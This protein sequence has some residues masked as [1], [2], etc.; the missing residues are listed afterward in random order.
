MEI[1]L[2]SRTAATMPHPHEQKLHDVV[3]SLMFSS[4]NFCVAALTVDR[5]RRSPIASPAPPLTVSRN[6][7]RRLIDVAP[8]VFGPR[9]ACSSAS[10]PALGLVLGSMIRA[11]FPGDEGIVRAIALRRDPNE[12]PVLIHKP[13]ILVA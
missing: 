10:I 6:Q 7:S 9:S 8:S 1:S 3:N 11:L 13:T 2:P 4:F 5:S 12:S